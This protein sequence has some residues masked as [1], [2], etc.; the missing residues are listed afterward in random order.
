MKSW[1]TMKKFRKSNQPKKMELNEYKCLSTANKIAYS[2]LL[3]SC[4]YE[5]VFNVVERAKATELPK[6]DARKVLLDLTT[7]YEPDDEATMIELK[8]EFVNLKLN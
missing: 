1:T 2:A 6:G 8:T 3:L 5:I 4:V 7:K